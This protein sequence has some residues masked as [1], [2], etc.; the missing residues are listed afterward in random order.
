MYQMTKKKK[1]EFFFKKKVKTKNK[2]W[3]QKRNSGTQRDIVFH[4]NK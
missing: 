1:K 3:K 2:N 4:K